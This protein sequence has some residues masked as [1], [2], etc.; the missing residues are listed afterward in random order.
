MPTTTKPK[1]KNNSKKVLK[2]EFA[3]RKQAMLRELELNI[4]TMQQTLGL[5]TDGDMKSFVR[6]LIRKLQKK[7]ATK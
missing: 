1:L 7:S 2:Q 6:G 3:N 5:T 4:L